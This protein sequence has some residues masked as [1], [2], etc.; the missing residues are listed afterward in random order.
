LKK[1][2]LGT[3]IRRQHKDSKIGNREKEKK[4]K[5]KKR[6]KNIRI[7]RE[8]VPSLLSSLISQSC[9]WLVGGGGA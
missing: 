3:G 8:A 7:Q 5:K 6:G 4:E 2:P 1:C 9:P